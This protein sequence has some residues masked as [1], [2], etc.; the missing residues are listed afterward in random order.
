MDIVEFF[1][2][3]N[4]EHLEAYRHLNS[5]GSWPPSFF[6]VLQAQ[7]L[8]FSPFWTVGLHYKLAGAY[9]DLVLARAEREA[10][11][12]ARLTALGRS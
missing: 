10:A 8:T 7:N 5:T 3:N 6:L 12:K 1:D 11:A 2:I 9:V 4:T